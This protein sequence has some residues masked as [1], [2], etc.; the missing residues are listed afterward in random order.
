MYK[1]AFSGT[2]DDFS[3]ENLDDAYSLKGYLCYKTIL[4][5]KVTLDLQSMNFSV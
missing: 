2:S 3:L 5:D 4:S 1:H